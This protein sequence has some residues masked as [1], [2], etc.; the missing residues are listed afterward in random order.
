MRAGP[1][2]NQ[3]TVQ[4]YGV[5]INTLRYGNIMLF[6]SLSSKINLAISRAYENPLSNW[7]S[8]T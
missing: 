2:Q 3:I 7:K 4:F 1:N 5:Q 8:E 6:N